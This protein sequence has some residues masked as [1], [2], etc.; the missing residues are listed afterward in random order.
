MVTKHVSGIDH[1]ALQLSDLE[2]THQPNWL[3][4]VLETVNIIRAKYLPHVGLLIFTVFIIFIRVHLA[5]FFE[6]GH[7]TGHFP[8]PNFYFL[9]LNFVVS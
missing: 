4:K 9:F 1:I 7:K 3:T 2:A 8:F 6:P 5:N